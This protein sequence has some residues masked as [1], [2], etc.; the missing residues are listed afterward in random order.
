M[1]HQPCPDLHHQRHVFRAAFSFLS[2]FFFFFLRKIF[3]SQIM[4]KSAHQEPAQ[5]HRRRRRRRKEGSKSKSR[6]RG[7]AHFNEEEAATAIQAAFRGHLVRRAAAGPN[8]SAMTGPREHLRSKGRSSTAQS[9]G[10]QKAKTPAAV[11]DE[12]DDE[13]DAAITI[14]AAFLGYKARKD[15]RRRKGRFAFKAPRKADPEEE[16]AT[17][18]QAAVRGR[19]VRR[20][21]KRQEDAAVKIQAIQRGRA[22]R[23]IAQE[24][25]RQMEIRNLPPLPTGSAL[26]AMPLGSV[27]ISFFF[28]FFNK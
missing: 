12:S 9:L 1:D 2:L 5:Q 19:L 7:R 16:A 26:G 4:P 28:F 15:T 11:E 24:E 20:E 23:K 25:R 27:T 13:E 3:S 8:L 14:Q 18:I 22:A 21:V 6:S 17:A 10:S